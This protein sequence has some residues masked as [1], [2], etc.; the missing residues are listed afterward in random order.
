MKL[1][2]GV[3]TVLLLAIMLELFLLGMLFDWHLFMD[4]DRFEELFFGYIQ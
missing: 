2:S 4:Q 1:S 3:K